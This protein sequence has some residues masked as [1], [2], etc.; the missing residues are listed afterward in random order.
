MTE[1]I[2]VYRRAGRKAARYLIKHQRPNGAFID[3][4]FREDVYHKNCYSLSVAG[5]WSEAHR[6]ATWVRDNELRPSG[7]LLHCYS[8]G[9]MQ[10][11]KDAWMLHGVHRLARFEISYPLMDWIATFQAPC[12][13]FV[14]EG[15]E[16]AWVRSLTTAW[17]GVAAL[18]V[19]RL[20]VAHRAGNCLLQMLE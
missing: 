8:P 4:G 14:C 1:R 2:Q 19:G 17:C 20:D 3:E 11:Y 13:G 15:R 16:D 5:F 6:L 12:G 9:R 7:E 10:V 18:Y